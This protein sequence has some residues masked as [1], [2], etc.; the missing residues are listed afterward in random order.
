MDSADRPDEGGPRADI[1]AHAVQMTRA[2]LDAQVE[3]AASAG[4]SDRHAA[5]TTW[6]S[7]TLDRIHEFEA[8]E[9]RGPR[10]LH[11]GEPAEVS[12]FL[13]LLLAGSPHENAGDGLRGYDTLY[14]EDQGSG[15][16]PH[17]GT[18]QAA[19][20]ASQ[21]RGLAAARASPEWGIPGGWRDAGFKELK[22]TFVD[23]F[24]GQE[25]PTILYVPESHRADAIARYGDMLVESKHVV[26]VLKAKVKPDGV[27]DRFTWRITY[28]DKA[29]SHHRQENTFAA[30]VNS[31]SVRAICQDAVELDP[32]ERGADASRAVGLLADDVEGA[33]YIG[34]SPKEGEP[35]FRV[36]Y[37]FV[38]S[39]LADFGYPQKNAKGERM[40]FFIRGNLPG[41]RD[42]GQIWGK[43]FTSFL[44]REGFTQ[45]VVDRRVFFLRGEPGKKAKIITGVHVDDCLTCVRDHAAGEKYLS[46]WRARFGGK[47][48]AV[49]LNSAGETVRHFLGLRIIM[50]KEEV[51]IDSPR[52]I[53]DLRDKLEEG[54]AL[55]ESPR[56]QFVSCD[57]PLASNALVRLR[58][59]PGEV[60]PSGDAL[61]GPVTQASE[62]ARELARSLLGLAGFVVIMF[63]PD[64][65]LAYAALAQQLGKNFTNVTWRCTLQFASYMVATGDLPLVLRRSGKGAAAYADS[66]SM[67]AGSGR[68]W[69]GFGYGRPGSG[70]TLYRCLSPRILSDSS[71]GNELI[72]ATLL[73]KEVI[74][75]RILAT[76]LGILKAGE[77]TDLFMDA[78]VVLSGVAMD[79]VSRESRYLSTRLA[80]L[81]QGVYDR[82][83]TLLKIKT[84]DNPAD[85]FTKPLVGAMFR[86]LRALVLGL[87]PPGPEAFD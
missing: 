24:P 58:S 56:Q 65:A 43:V 78:S 84:E 41:R 49:T 83:I 44:L 6:D 7:P 77:A 17:V 69:G 8:L 36:L 60:G 33:Y 46:N 32:A 30:C 1:P 38:P 22:R 68:S 80:M 35:G 70:L 66:S 53:Q 29:P 23:V 55:P 74:A 14:V 27:F 31:S 26:I 28:A 47:A 9:G 72:V 25:G 85:I 5:E 10:V 19:A 48:S 39:G 64:G 50:G 59:M 13:D 54:F 52:L 79:R 12:S 71:G 42:A 81:R 34:N 51:R 45:S 86:R 57:A 61:G 87:N 3:A 16:E 73:L 62:P 82:V 76:E 37:G 21:P 67:N 18:A 75:E 11:S 15:E 20:G 2:D 63:R 4:A 40:L